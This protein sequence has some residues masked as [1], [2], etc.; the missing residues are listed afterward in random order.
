MTPSRYGALPPLTQADRLKRAHRVMLSY[1]FDLG[2]PMSV[3][4]IRTVQAGLPFNSGSSLIGKVPRGSTLVRAH[5]GWGFVAST[6]IFASV[7]QATTNILVFGLVTLEGTGTESVPDPRLS[8]ANPA[9]PLER[10]LWWEGRAPTVR[11]YDAIGQTITWTDSPRTEAADSR[12]QVTASVA[13]GHTLDVWASWS[14]GFPWESSGHA[15][16]W[17][18][19]SIGYQ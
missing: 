17:Y 14:A 8:P 18:W 1:V 6:S 9:P 16:V 4:W 5:F 10:W 19:A 13:V 7:F 3:T 11:S 15:E 12:G 2:K